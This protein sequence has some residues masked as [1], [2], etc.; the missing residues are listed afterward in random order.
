[1]KHHGSLRRCDLGSL[2][3]PR[4]QHLIGLWGPLRNVNGSPSSFLCRTITGGPAGI[5]Q[6]FDVSRGWEVFNGSE[7]AGSGWSP[8][9]WQCDQ[10]IGPRHQFQ[11]SFLRW[12]YYEPCS[13][14]ERCWYVPTFPQW[15]WPI[16]V[17]CPL[18]PCINLVLWQQRHSV[19]ATRSTMHLNPSELKDT[20]TVP[21]AIRT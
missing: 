3:L 11:A 8:Y 9:D 15:I 12:I 14:R 4:P 6:F 13:T 1:M 20:W 19:K 16:W 10:Q 21:E 2:L 17:R 18:S 5:S 7:L